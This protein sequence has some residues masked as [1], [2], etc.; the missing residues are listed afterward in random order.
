MDKVD[1]IAREVLGQQHP[2]TPLEKILVH[3]IENL[4]EEEE[5]E[6]EEC[7][8]SLEA[9]QRQVAV[10]TKKEELKKDEVQEK[11]KLELKPLPAH[12]KC[13]S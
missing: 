1:V 6:I 10:H 4:D 12:L 8:R 9:Q 3:S 5:K 11:P 2:S 7:L 13:V